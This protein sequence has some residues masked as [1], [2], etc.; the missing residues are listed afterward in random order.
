MIN[1]SG[2]GNG[3][4]ESTMKGKKRTAKRFLDSILATL[5]EIGKSSPLCLVHIDKN[6]SSSAIL[7]SF[8]II[9]N[10]FQTAMFTF[11]LCKIRTTIVKSGLIHGAADVLLNL[12]EKRDGRTKEDIYSSHERAKCDCSF[13]WSN[14]GRSFGRSTGG[15]VRWCIF[16]CQSIVIVPFNREKKLKMLVDFAFV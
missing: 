5:A 14:K 13:L 7:L 8:G 10:S 16:V 3:E 6:A 15:M 1:S 2:D 12:Y 11:L 4:C 9:Q